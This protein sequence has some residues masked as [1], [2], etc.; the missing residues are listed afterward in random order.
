MIVIEST[1]AGLLS[2]F[3][4]AQVIGMVGHTGVKAEVKNIWINRVNIISVLTGV[5][6]LLSH[7]R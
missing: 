7:I 3:I 6:Y 5:L 1:V 4:W 2:Y